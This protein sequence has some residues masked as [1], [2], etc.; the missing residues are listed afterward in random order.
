MSKQAPRHVR[1]F[2]VPGEPGAWVELR[3]LTIGEQR[4]LR[5]GEAPSESRVTEALIDVVMAWSWP[6]PIDAS[7]LDELDFPTVSWL[8]D[9]SLQHNAGTLSDPEKKDETSGSSGSSTENPGL[10]PT[11]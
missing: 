2:E 10:T 7:G 4:A 11:L 8:F 9:T 1:R 3:R 5:M 6:Y